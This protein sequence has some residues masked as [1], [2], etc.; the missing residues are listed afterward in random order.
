MRRGT[1]STR[2]E[3]AACLAS[4][5]LSRLHGGWKI[6]QGQAGLKIAAY[7]PHFAP[8]SRARCCRGN[9]ENINTRTHPI[10]VRSSGPF[11]FILIYHIYTWAK[12]INISA[13]TK[14]DLL[15]NCTEGCSTTDSSPHTFCYLFCSLKSD[16][17]IIY[18]HPLLPPPHHSTL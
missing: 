12:D 8:G 7:W 17:G 18:N 9:L 2:R 3:S 16:I 11:S 5:A 13:W 14:K 15:S 6:C 10:P 1:Q 4:C